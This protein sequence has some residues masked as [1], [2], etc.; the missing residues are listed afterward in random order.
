M[1]TK[2]KIAPLD[3]KDTGITTA[4]AKKMWPKLG[5]THLGVVE[6]RVAERSEGDEDAKGVKLVIDNIELADEKTV[7]HTRELQRALY[8]ARQV[9][10]A[11]TAGVEDTPVD[12]VNRGEVT[13]L[14]CDH[15]E[16]RM[17]AKNINHGRRDGVQCI[18]VPCRHTV[19]EADGSDCLCGMTTTARP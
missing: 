1:T 7:E 15:C 6:L 8:L 11:L 9:D 4:H 16:H 17:T 3:C 2:A 5:S 13:V 10:K 18:W 19:T 12:V 14:I